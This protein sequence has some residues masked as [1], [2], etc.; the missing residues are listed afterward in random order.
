MP[1]KQAP[2]LRRIPYLNSD[3][4]ILPALLDVV[5]CSPNEGAHACDVGTNEEEEEEEAGRASKGTVETEDC[6]PARTRIGV[7]SY[8]AHST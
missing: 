3:C 4:R 5:A 7:S 8:R 2:L 1:K 6:P